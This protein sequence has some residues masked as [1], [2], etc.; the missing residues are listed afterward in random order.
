MNRDRSHR[1]RLLKWA[2]VGFAPVVMVGALLTSGCGI[3]VGPTQELTIDEGLTAAA[4][5]DVEVSMGAGKLSLSGGAA[6]LASGIIRY[7][8]ESWKPQVSRSD[9]A[10][11]IKQGSQKGLSG[12]GS[13]I[14]NEWTLQLGNSPIRLS[15]N[16]GAYEGTYDL[17]GLTLQDL[18]IKDG[19]AKTQVMF[20]SVNPG[21]M[22]TFRYE[23]GAS[24][25][26]MTG[27]ANANFKEMDFSGGAGS[28]SFDFSGQV[29]TDGIVRIESG[30]GSVEVRIPKETL[31]RVT[32]EGALN[33]V[34]LEG[35]WT[36]SGKTHSTPAAQAGGSGRTLTITVDMSVGTL[37]LI[38]E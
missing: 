3:N 31:A 7:N 27:L 18:A 26:T 32:V 8:V 14:V 38:T 5:T 19:A 4:V 1:H 24:K 10:L 23:T 21:Q 35:P 25:V 9:S 37:K 15:V 22:E 36:S 2:L 20:E 33:D 16:A 11:T 12:L 17:S 13:D 28:Y 6:A 29:R 30:V 34:S